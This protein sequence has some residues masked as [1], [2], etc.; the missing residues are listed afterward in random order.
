MFPLR[1]SL[2][3]NYF[4]SVTLTQYSTQYST[5]INR[6]QSI[7]P[8]SSLLFMGEETELR[9]EKF[10]LNLIWVVT[11]DLKGSGYL[12]IS[13]MVQYLYRAA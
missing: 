5:V 2:V 4:I 3:H 12:H 8:A 9:Q 1:S 7:R 11:S 13:R 6:L 10:R